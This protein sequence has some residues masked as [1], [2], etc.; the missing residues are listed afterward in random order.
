[1]VEK[2]GKTNHKAFENAFNVFQKNRFS[3]AAYWRAFKLKYSLVKSDV[4]SG[5]Y[6]IRNA[7]CF[8]SNQISFINSYLR[9]R[10]GMLDALAPYLSQS[11]NREWIY[12]G[13]A[14]YV[15][16]NYSLKGL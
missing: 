13:Y 16:L 6:A 14:G 11:P 10:K 9:D 8:N 12:S 7:G 15:S 1:M 5:Q 4:D 2:N 3:D